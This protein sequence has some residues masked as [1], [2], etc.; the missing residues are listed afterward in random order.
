MHCSEGSLSTTAP[1]EGEEGGK[2]GERDGRKG[3]GEI[4]EKGER[5][6]G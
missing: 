5:E 1:G 3:E 6:G 4:A 2:E